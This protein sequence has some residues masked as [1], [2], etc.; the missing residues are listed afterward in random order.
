MRYLFI[1]LI[2][3]LLMA[4]A[5]NK[6]AEIVPPEERDYMV[7]SQKLQSSVVTDDDNFYFLSKVGTSIYFTRLSKTGY[8]DNLLEINSLLPQND[9][10]FNKK[11]NPFLLTASPLKDGVILYF[12]H[13]KGDMLFTNILEWYKFD[14]E[15]NIVWHFI[16]EE[17]FVNNLVGLVEK[18]KNT[19]LKVYNKQDWNAFPPT[20]GIEIKEINLAGE[21]IDSVENTEFKSDFY[22]IRTLD[23]RNEQLYLLTSSGLSASSAELTI[24]D[25]DLK[26]AKQTLLGETMVD[27]LSQ[28]EI[29][30]FDNSFVITYYSGFYV[31]ELFYNVVEMDF[32]GNLLWKKS[33][34]VE[35]QEFAFVYGVDKQ[36]EKTFL[37]GG[38]TMFESAKTVI[39]AYKSQLRYAAL[40]IDNQA[41]TINKYYI[42][43]RFS[44]AAAAVIYDANEIAHILTV[45][46]VY[47]Q[48]DKIMLFNVDAT[49]IES[50][51]NPPLK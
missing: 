34:N 40:L 44:T 11:E 39:D 12:T 38:A 41:N 27:F 33:V 48:Y 23:Y 45:K 35:N 36:N 37:V 8:I 29:H 26:I 46:R 14:F 4:V 16:D 28:R 22:F 1:I 6:E 5:C 3:T 15:G 50:F 2:S 32:D 20:N 9:T 24:F 17:N 30:F 18:D 49:N 47:N 51:I 7:F 42:M 13:T 25:K 10:T 19:I 43:S 31:P 21:V